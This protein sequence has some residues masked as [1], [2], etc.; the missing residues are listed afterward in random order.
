MSGITLSKQYGVNPSVLQCP[1][2]GKEHSIALFGTKWKDK[3]GK[4]AEAP[5]VLA[6]PTS[7]CD[8]CKKV[9]DQGGAFIIEVKD[10]EAEKKAQ[11]P[12]RTGRLIAIKKEASEKM[13]GQYNP[14]AYMEE[15]MFEQIFGEIMKSSPEENSNNN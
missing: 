4:T 11:N 12:Y 9:I 5:R 3:D 2:C 8:N 6:T 14:V 1:I 13:F 10:G 7:Y 15:T